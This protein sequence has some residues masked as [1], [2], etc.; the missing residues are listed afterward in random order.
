MSVNYIRASFFDESFVFPALLVF[1]V[2][3]LVVCWCFVQRI[4]SVNVILFNQQYTYARRNEM[5]D[6]YLAIIFSQKELNLAPADKQ[7]GDLVFVS[8]DLSF[9]FI[10]TNLS[11]A[12]F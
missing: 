6:T 12:K 5:L 10:R 9:M 1:A 3:T 2:P 7:G 4:Q 8:I 11:Y